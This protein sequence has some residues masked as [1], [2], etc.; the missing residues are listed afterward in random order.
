VTLFAGVSG[1]GLFRSLDSGSTWSYLSFDL[2]SPYALDTLGDNLYA[3]I[4]GQGVYV[5]RDNGTTWRARSQ[6]LVS[7]KVQSLVHLGQTLFASFLDGPIYKLDSA[8]E[9][10][11]VSNQS[12]SNNLIIS[13]IYPNPSHGSSAMSITV[14]SPS[15]MLVT[16]EVIDELG[17]VIST[18]HRM[19]AQGSSALSIDAPLRAGVYFVRIASQHGSAL[20]A[21]TVEK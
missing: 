1:K 9:M 15:R 20:R 8:D 21:F 5:S 3:A 17:R 18:S 13:S 7:M 2:F 16:T 4:Y 10:A 14:E 6:G 11:S 19:I 12:Q